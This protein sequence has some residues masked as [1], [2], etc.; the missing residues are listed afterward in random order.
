MTT[1]D[2]ATPLPSVYLSHGGGPW[3]YMDGPM[4]QAHAALEVALRA[5]PQRLGRTPRAVLMVSAHWE[6]PQFTLQT[7][8]RPGMLYDYGGFPPHTYQVT[9]PAPGAPELATQV[10]ALMQGAGLDCGLDPT[11]GYDHGAFVPMA[12]IYPQ[13]DVPMLQLSLKVGLDPAVHLAAGRALA[14]LRSQG[15]LIIGSGSSFH[16]LA[17]RRELV[18]SASAQFDQWLG[19]TSVDRTPAER[20][21]R[22]I[23]WATAPAARLAHAREEHLIPLMVAV[24]AA[25]SEPGTRIYHETRFMG[26]ATA[27][28]YAF[29]AV[30]GPT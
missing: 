21:E 28:S 27:S 20:V 19:E 1:A 7:A 9:Y 14:P 10:Q 30:A 25:E 5:L 24:G 23:H 16:N 12:A 26:G 2:L 17:L 13:A 18:P 11:R 6:T 4:R 22:L 15:V 8:A 3:I 29:G